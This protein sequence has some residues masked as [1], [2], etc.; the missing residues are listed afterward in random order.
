MTKRVKVGDVEVGVMRNPHPEKSNWIVYRY[1]PRTNEYLS[2]TESETREKAEYLFAQ[3]TDQEKLRQQ[4]AAAVAM[5]TIDFAVEPKIYRDHP[6]YA[7]F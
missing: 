1:R 5:K 3:T 4:R 6:L 2:K 7:R